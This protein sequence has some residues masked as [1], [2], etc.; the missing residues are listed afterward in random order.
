M[1]SD[2]YD[3]DEADPMKSKA[4]ES[5]LWEIKVILFKA[6]C[7]CLNLV[8][9]ENMISVLLIICTCNEITICQILKTLIP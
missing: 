9:S 7:H 1:A 2:P 3:P 6:N 8:Y 5:S 4:M